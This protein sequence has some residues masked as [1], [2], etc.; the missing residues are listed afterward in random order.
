MQSEYLVKYQSKIKISQK[1]IV[2]SKIIPT[3]ALLIP[4]WGSLLY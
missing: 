1:N 3:F 2:N 4:R